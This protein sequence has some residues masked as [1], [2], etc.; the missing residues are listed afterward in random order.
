MRL[1][2]LSDIH[3]N[4]SAL[5]AALFDIESRGA[6]GIIFLGDAV[7]MGPRP[8]QTLDRLRSLNCP[9]VMGNTDRWL[10][11]PQP[12]EVPDG[13]EKMQIEAELWSAQQLAPADRDFIMTFMPTVEVALGDGATL[14]CCHAS[15]LSDEAGIEADTPADEVERRLAGR[16]ATVVAAGHTHQQMLRRYGTVTLVNSGSVGQPAVRDPHTGRTNRP[17]W[18]E[19][20]LLEW[21]GGSLS[22]EFHRVGYDILPVVR[23]ILESGMPH[24]ET[25][26]AEWKG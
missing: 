8:R 22:L 1:A 17:A 21:A 25:W 4:L 12:P 9:L 13:A 3:G 7:A 10:L 11:A 26:A 24:A 5:D 2:L 16:R 20:A 15:P 23:A 6:H 14:L 19:Y 18:A